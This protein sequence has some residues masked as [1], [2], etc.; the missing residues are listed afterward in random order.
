MAEGIQLV[1][2]GEVAARPRRAVVSFWLGVAGLVV[3]LAWS[4]SEVP[5]K[6][7]A[8]GRFQ[9]TY[10]DPERNVYLGKAFAPGK[11]LYVGEG[12]NFS[13]AVTEGANG[14]RQFHVSGKVEASTELMDMRLQLM[15]GHLPALV[16]RD[17][18]S[19]LVVGMGSATAGLGAPAARPE[20]VWQA[21]P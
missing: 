10:N 4:V 17:P 20:L 7:V 13:V 5:W 8:L 14:V 3:W 19:V 18:R 15:L 2:D 11:K 9:P 16:H 21:E 1:V 6:L 12:M